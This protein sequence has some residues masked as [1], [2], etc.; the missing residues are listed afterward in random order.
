VEAASSGMTLFDSNKPPGRN[1][2][3]M[4]DSASILSNVS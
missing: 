3:A 4:F 1:I 2:A